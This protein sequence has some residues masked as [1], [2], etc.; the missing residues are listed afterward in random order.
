MM[1]GGTAASMMGAGAGSGLAGSL[2]APQAATP[3][4]TALGSAPAVGGSSM[5][6]AGVGAEGLSALGLTPGMSDPSMWSQLQKYA[7]RG[8]EGY[9][10]AQQLQKMSQGPD[11]PP[12]AIARPP[13]GGGGSGQELAQLQA[14]LSN[15]VGQAQLQRLLQSR[16]LLG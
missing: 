15:P 7:S 4:F 8:M 11:M 6:G 2:L 13:S 12:P 9:Q 10:K 1:G 14:L 16:G 5:F 3:F